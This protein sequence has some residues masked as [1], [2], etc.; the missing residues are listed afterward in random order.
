MISWPRLLV[1]VIV[2]MSCTATLAQHSS[3]EGAHESNDDPK[4]TRGF[5]TPSGN[6]HYSLSGTGLGLTGISPV[7]HFENRGSGAP[8]T[9]RL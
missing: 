9:S 8:K 5:K 6:I 3:R 4:A 2:A 7:R 1:M